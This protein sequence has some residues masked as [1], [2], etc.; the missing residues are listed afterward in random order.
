MEQQLGQVELEPE[1]K[2][3]RSVFHRVLFY[4]LVLVVACLIG[5]VGFM[6]VRLKQQARQLAGGQVSTDQLHGDPFNLQGGGT[7]QQTPAETPAQGQE[8]APYVDP[9]AKPERWVTVNWLPAWQGRDPKCVKEGYCDNDVSLAG[10]VTTGP[11]QGKDVYIRLVY[12]LG[13]TIQHFVKD[14]GKEVIFEDEN[15]KMRGISDAPETIAWQG[16]SYTLKKGW[17]ESAFSNAKREPLPAFTSPEFGPVYIE[18]TRKCFFV[19]LPDHTALGYNIVM[20]F[21]TDEGKVRAQW[22]DNVSRNEEY[23]FTR[24]T[25]GGMCTFLAFKP[26]AEVKPDQRLVV[27]ARTSNGDSLYG[28]KSKTDQV[29]KDMYNDKNTAAYMQDPNGGTTMQDKSRY[30]YTQFLSYYPLLYWKDPL[31]RFV[32]FTNRRFLPQAEMCKPVIY[33]YPT[34]EKNVDVYVNPNGGLTKTEPYYGSGWHVTAYPDGRIV[35][36]VGGGTYKYLFWEGI[37]LQYPQPTNGFVVATGELNHFFDEVLPKLGLAGRE[38]TDFK[39][40]WVSRLAGTK[41][42]Y[43]FIHFMDKVEF[44][45]LAPVKVGPEFPDTLI[46]VMM[47]AKTLSTKEAR[48]LQV[49]PKTPIRKGFTFVEWGGALLQ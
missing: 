37:G 9:S 7:G 3:T 2:E 30:T 19:E 4:A 26:E 46:R 45:A 34:E 13:T 28:L 10:K 5:V 27:V 33:L 44:S 25:C 24:P 49:L 21:V 29:L 18:E 20:P 15:I 47:T 42:P 8:P 17:V 40:Y 22:E 38:I 16:T 14:G 32:E 31:G 41:Q 23:Q 39:E 12:E 36:R 6:A 48:P 35:D 43:V 1:K 11:Y